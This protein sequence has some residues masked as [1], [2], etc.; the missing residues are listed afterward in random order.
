[1]S[2]TETT[3]VTEAYQ[4]DKLPKARPAHRALDFGQPLITPS[5]LQKQQHKPWKARRAELS[6]LDTSHK[7]A[8]SLERVIPIVSTGAIN[9][10]F[11]IVKAATNSNHGPCLKL[12]PQVKCY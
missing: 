8:H 4:Q 3:S 10:P 12:K 9:N 7:P 2:K 6:T 1:M 5:G 11:R